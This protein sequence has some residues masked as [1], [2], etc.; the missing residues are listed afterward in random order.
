MRSILEREYHDV[1]PQSESCK[2]WEILNLVKIFIR[3]SFLCRRAPFPDRRIFSLDGISRLRKWPK[4]CT[5]WL[6]LIIQNFL[7]YLPRVRVCG[8]F[9]Y[10]F[11]ITDQI[12]DR[13]TDRITDRKKEEKVLKNRKVKSFIKYNALKIREKKNYIMWDNS[14]I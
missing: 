13:I 10:N 8:K 3:E 11:R 7:T 2:S 4:P 9:S 14:H 6:T 12:S 1:Y 5:F